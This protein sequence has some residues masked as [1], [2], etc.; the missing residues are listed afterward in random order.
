MGFRP[1]ARTLAAR[2]VLA[3]SDDAASAR[4]GMAA[5]LVV[6]GGGTG[7]MAA[8]LA[9]LRAG[10]RVVMTEPTDWIGGQ[11]T[12]Q[13]VPPD[14]HP[15]IE[16]FGC[17]R[18]YRELRERV[19]GYYRR[20]YPLTEAARSRRDLNPGNGGVS[21]L[22]HEPRVGLAA[23]HELIAPF[24][25]GG[26]LTI[27]HHREV[28]RAEADGDR[29]RAVAVR[30]ARS[31]VETVLEAPIFI[32]ATELG[33]LL[34]LAGIEHLTG[35]EAAKETGEAHAPE[36]AAPANHQAFT[37]CFAIDH[38]EGADFTIPRPE[39][40][41]FWRDFVPKLEPAWPG[42]LLSFTD[43]HP[44]TLERRVHAFDPLCGSRPG[45]LWTYRRIAD[46][47]NFLPGIY[48]GDIC[49]VNW[50]QND[51]M[52]GNLFDERAR[53]PA[54]SAEH[55]RRAREQSLALL[56]WLQT[57]APRPDGTS[58]WK[59]L[60][61]R[62]DVLGTEDGLAKH[63]YVRESRRIRAEFTVLEQH[64]GTEARMAATGKRRE[65]VEAERFPDS[66]G[67]GS[68]RI[69]LHPSSGGDNYIDISSLPFQVP[70]GALIPRRVENVLAGAKNFGVTHITNGCYRLHPV[71]W[72]IGE[73]AGALAAAALAK[74]EPPR[75]IRNHAP[76][77]GE[78]QARLRADGVE[79]EWPRLRPR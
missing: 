27:L 29:V 38:V 1:R 23:L 75:R 31:G 18:S 47:G 64:V 6:L 57:E 59:G 67:V 46:R 42:K 12:Q 71:E 43:V 53:A 7:G 32:D 39:G 3:A 77:L 69:D 25:S 51:Y 11:L 14:E 26:R 56:Y 76:L 45:G 50:P 19:R 30:D 65:E 60:R 74:K 54:Q 4:R 2:Q 63:P 70:L 78:L 13:G 21:K 28:A 72:N 68:Y 73:A 48:A 33:D 55:R 41:E 24:A 37:W 52:L 34:P 44:Q 61:L 22:C 5:D 17:T 8:A 79:T 62:G 9:A 20:N 40:Y 58:G 10:L 66:A 36:A 16:S 35:A 49:L 15:W